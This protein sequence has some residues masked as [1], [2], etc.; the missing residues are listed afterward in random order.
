M[1]Q[2]RDLQLSRSAVLHAEMGE[3]R[4][5]IQQVTESVLSRQP[6]LEQL[7]LQLSKFG[8]QFLSFLQTVVNARVTRKF[9][10]ISLQ[11]LAKTIHHETVAQGRLDSP[12]KIIPHSNPIDRILTQQECTLESQVLVQSLHH[13]MVNYKLASLEREVQIILIIILAW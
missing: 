12:S 2:N 11:A 7:F 10:M 6:C 1:A 8:R 5:Q 3:L 4:A 9:K 13:I